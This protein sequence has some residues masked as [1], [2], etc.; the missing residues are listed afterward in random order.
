[1]KSHKKVRDELGISEHEDIQLSPIILKSSPGS[2]E[3]E[4][5]KLKES[6]IKIK[7][8]NSNDSN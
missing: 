8:K 6:S 4:L 5:Q 2:I 1:M 7:Y 3:D